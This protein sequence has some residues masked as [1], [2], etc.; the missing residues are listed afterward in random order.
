MAPNVHGLVEQW[1]DRTPDAVAVTDPSTGVCLS[2][3]ELWARSGAIAAGC[4]P[5][6]LIALRLPRSTDL[7]VAQLGV[8]RAGAAYLPIDAQAPQSR[9][10]TILADS[11]AVE[12]QAAELPVPP[13]VPVSGEDPCYVM[14]TSGSTGTPKGVVIP[15]R[16]VVRLVTRSHH[17]VIA[18]GDRCAHAANPAFDAST[19]EV[20]GALAA[21]ATLVIMPSVLDLTIDEW[22]IAV[23]AQRLD[24]MFLTTSLFHLVARTRPDAFGSLANLVVG[25]EQLSLDAV[26]A[27]LDA[28]GPGRLVNGYGPT[29][30]TTFAA[31]FDCTPSSLA[32]LSRV[33]VGFPLPDTTL[34]VLDDTRQPVPPGTTGEL[35]IGG[36][37]VALGYLG[38]TSVSFT[39]DPLTGSFLYR[40]G[41]LARQLRTGAIEL[42]G[43]VD[44][45]VKLRGFRIELEEIERA[46]LASAPLAEAAV[47]KIGDGPTAFL[48]AFV[49][50][51]TVDIDS[52]SARLAL[53][54]PAYMLPARW[55]TLD[56]LPFGPTGK[57]DRARLRAMAESAQTSA[58]GVDHP[59]H[60]VLE[61]CREV[62]R[63]PAVRP[64]D[65]F[66]DLGGNS[67][68]AVQVATRIRHRLHVRVE[69]ADV[70]LADSCGELARRLA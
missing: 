69:P 59:G 9:V 13:A 36:P 11:G 48:A 25:G 30:A 60:A 16:A 33:P 44:R 23:R 68:L 39:D 19:F 12:L 66:L 37:G 8:L 49:S 20:W 24:T 31:Y 45:Q 32:G 15:H 62:L 4:R 50:P 56:E 53:D 51:A 65:N 17:C 14:Y 64:S 28:G 1:V 55:I 70:L 21:G 47:E 29:E 67:L 38:R 22:A 3:A 27:V 18:P 58:A 6:D 2:Y 7:V 57:L 54:L 40:T 35:C 5:G 63:V 46:L 41:D 61:I 10:D 52:L 34:A 42:L 26:R 43:R